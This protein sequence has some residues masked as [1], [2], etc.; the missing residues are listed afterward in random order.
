MSTVFKEGVFSVASKGG[1]D[2]P[3]A[4]DDLLE[5]LYRLDF[6][7]PD[8][9]RAT[10]AAASMPQGMPG[11]QGLSPAALQDMLGS[12]EAREMMDQLQRNPQVLQQRMKEEFRHIPP[13]EQ[14][15]FLD[16]LASTGMG[17][18]DFWEKFLRG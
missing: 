2:A 18:R 3:V 11:M 16:M 1:S 4:F 15:R 5:E 7:R 12:G 6:P 9:G 8:G 13:D 14:D 10:S 17:D